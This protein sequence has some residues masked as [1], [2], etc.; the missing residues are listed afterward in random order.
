MGTVPRRSFRPYRTAVYRLSARKTVKRKRSKSPL[1]IGS[2]IFGISFEKERGEAYMQY[3]TFA[4]IDIGSYDVI[5]EISRSPKSRVSE[6]WIRSAI[7]WSLEK[8][9][10]RWGKSARKWKRSSAACSQISCGSW[11]ATAWMLTAPWL[12]AQSVRRR[13]ASMSLEKSVS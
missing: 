8:I 10:T 3:S 6:A 7:G 4:A 11:R 12:R 1:G 2:G 13:T 5:L 9:R